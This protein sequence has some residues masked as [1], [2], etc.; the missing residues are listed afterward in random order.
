[1][2]DRTAPYS[3]IIKSTDSRTELR[4]R[5]DSVAAASVC[6]SE[7]LGDQSISPRPKNRSRQWFFDTYHRHLHTAGVNVRIQQSNGRITQITQRRSV[8]GQESNFSFE[9][10]TE[11]PVGNRPDQ[12]VVT[13]F[14]AP[15]DALICAH[16][17]DLVQLVT[18]EVVQEAGIH[19]HDS[20][21]VSVIIETAEIYTEDNEKS[22]RVRHLVLTHTSGDRKD[23]YRFAETISRRFELV[24][25]SRDPQDV[26]RQLLIGKSQAGVK[27]RKFL[28]SETSTA[29]DVARLSF[30]QAVA[31][32]IANRQAA[33]E[34]HPEAI[35]QL[36]V[37]LRRFRS[38]ERM[39][40][41]PLQ[42]PLLYKLVPVAKEYG[43]ILGYARDWDVFSDVT[44]PKIL[45]SPTLDRADQAILASL[46]DGAEDKREI[47][48]ERV[49]AALNAYAFSEFCLGLKQLTDPGGWPSEGQRALELPA[50]EYA[51]R[52]LGKRLKKVNL[53]GEDLASAPAHARHPLR[54]ELKKLRYA[55]QAFRPLYPKEI[56][57][58]YLTA[59]SELQDAFGVMNDAVVAREMALIAAKPAF[60]NQQLDVHR[61]MGASYAIGWSA[62][63]L[64]GQA[65]TVYQA[66]LSFEAM[67]P[68]WLAAQRALADSTDLGV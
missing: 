26:A 37:G 65:E 59:L 3:R 31:Q 30:E 55:V 49:R 21:K 60:Q 50:G 41:K 44:I 4:F 68:F 5:L 16:Q 66:W 63:Q 51:V 35:K 20:A 47:S 2:H 40:R 58:P 15:T 14:H 48:R 46:K 36:R 42:Y 1:M 67:Q 34:G 17:N 56:R 38:L 12:P 57:K 33:A 27:A 61:A 11:L 29:L 8:K 19:S 18:L 23:F 22:C 64:Q 62:Q 24:L 13:R 52:A 43:K 9:I 10:E 28:L 45:S 39:F 53:M 25:A 32:V 7:L 54:V 6:R